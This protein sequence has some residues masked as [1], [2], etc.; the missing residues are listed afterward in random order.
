MNTQ[1]GIRLGSA[2]LGVVIAAGFLLGTTASAGDAAGKIVLSGYADGAGGESLL[3]KNYGAII[4][5]LGA[6]GVSFTQDPVAASTNLCIAYIMTHDWAKADGACD[7]AIRV[8][9]LDTPTGTLYERINHDQEVGL[10]YSNRAVLRSLEAHPKDAASD[11]ARAVALAPSSELV[12][13]NRA[14]L[15]GATGS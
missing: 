5:E 1:H 12:M 14:A 8:A 15:T 9:K 4:D 2:A 7:Q 3:A 11:L 6:H 13:R 10:A